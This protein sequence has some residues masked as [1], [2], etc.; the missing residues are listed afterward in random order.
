M[1]GK[2]SEGTYVVVAG[3]HVAIG[4]VVADTIPLV[5]RVVL[6]HLVGLAVGLLLPVDLAALGSFDVRDCLLAVLGRSD[7][8][9]WR[10]LSTRARAGW[11]G[12]SECRLAEDAVPARVADWST[13]IRLGLLALCLWGGDVAA[14]RAWAQGDGRLSRSGSLGH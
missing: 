7:L 6:F 10:R 3:D 8:A 11:S 1:C 5:V 2:A 14:R 4:D 9:L 13:L 12:C